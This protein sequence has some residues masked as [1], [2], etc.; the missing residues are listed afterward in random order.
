MLNTAQFSAAKSASEARLLQDAVFD[1]SKIKSFG[2]FQKDAQEIT[3]ITQKTWLRVE[4]E[5]CRRQAVSAAQFS[6]YQ[7]NADLYPFWVY[8]GR[9]DSRERPEHVAMEGKVFR[10][11]SPAGD[12]CFPPI[13]W[14]CRCEGDQVDADYLRDNNL[15]ESTEAQ[16]QEFLQGNV[17]DQFQYNAAQQG[18]MPNEHSYFD[19]FP[20]A[21]FGDWNYFGLGEEGETELSAFASGTGLRYTIEIA[22][23]WRR[24]YHRDGKANLI[25]QNKAT[26]TNV[27]LG[28]LALHKISRHSKG[29]ENLPRTIQRP[30]EIW[31]LWEDPENQRVVLRNYILYG[32]ISYVVQTRDGDVYDAFAI[33][34][35]QANK[36]RKGV[37]LD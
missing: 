17:G 19:V 14:N 35:R 18:P 16:A 22:A 10:I 4:Y 2:K 5:A 33:S 11:G 6:E 28:D 36:F 29:M 3:D 20:N 7:K 9:M 23:E 24:K 13:D 25:F 1:G 31:S 8:R 27:R 30:T 37:I 21:N 34:R 15:T 12:K 26:L 32:K